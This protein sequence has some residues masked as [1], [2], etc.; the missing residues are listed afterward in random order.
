MYFP[1]GWSDKA[2][3]SLEEFQELMT[4]K[5]EKVMTNEP[6]QVTLVSQDSS[7]NVKEKLIAEKFAKQS[8]LVH[9]PVNLACIGWLISD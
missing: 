1:D 2:V 8:E 4:M 5:V 3:K 6:V 9:D 7:E